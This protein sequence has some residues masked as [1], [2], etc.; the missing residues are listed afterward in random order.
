MKLIRFV[1]NSETHSGAI[2]GDRVLDIGRATNGRLPSNPIDLLKDQEALEETKELLGRAAESPDSVPEGS[3]IPVGAV[4]VQAPVPRP[5]K[6]VCLGRNYRDHAAETGAD[7]PEEPV[8]FAKAQSSLIGPGDP[9]CL[10]RVA[11]KVD[12]EAELAVLVKHPI[13]HITAETAL[14]YVGGYTILCDVSARDY[15]HEKPGGQ[16]YLGKSF[17][18]FCPIG[19]VLTTADEI[20]DPHNLDIGCT[21]NGEVRQAANTG[22]MIFDIPTILA[23]LSDVF[24]LEPGDVVST[25]TPSGVGAGQ[26]PP[27]FLKS[28]DEVCCAISQIGELTNPVVGAGD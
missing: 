12:Y 8:V 4:D 3:L 14:D 28:G 20:P 25:G 23:Y 17:D 7:I 19:P 24:T 2:V 11:E 26:S 6:I 10:P 5:G 13:R 27:E 15:Q 9:V 16:W 1:H 21:V 18:T 22:Q